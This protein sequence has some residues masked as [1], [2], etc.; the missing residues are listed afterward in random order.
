MNCKTHSLFLSYEALTSRQVNQ[1]SMDLEVFEEN[2]KLK[3]TIRQQS[4]LID[5]LQVK[6][7]HLL[8][9]KEKKFQLFGKGSMNRGDENVSPPPQCTSREDLKAW[10]ARYREAKVYVIYF[11]KMMSTLQSCKLFN[12]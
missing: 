6:N 3:V 8:K 1:E 5:F 10:S 4:K 12:A 7:Q 9:K 11:C 2:L